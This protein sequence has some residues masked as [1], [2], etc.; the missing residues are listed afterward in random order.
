M[1]KVALLLAFEPRSEIQRTYPPLAL[2]YLASYLRTHVPEVEVRF[3]LTADEAAAFGPDLVGI[4]SV[5]QNLP[6]ATRLAAQLRQATDAPIALGGIHVSLLPETLPAPFDL[7]VL[8]EGER[9]LADL[10]RWRRGELARLDE[11]E[12]LEVRGE[13][14]RLV[15]TPPRTPIANLDE[16]PMPDLEGLGLTWRV[17]YR[18]RVLLYSARGCPYKCLF[19]SGTRFWRNYRVFSTEYLIREIEARS[20]AYGTRYFDFWD[21]LFIGDEKRFRA[22]AEAFMERALAQ[23]VI[24]GFS[25][26]SN[27]VTPERVRAFGAL[28]VENVNFGAESGSDRILAGAHKTGVTVAVNQRAIDLLHDQGIFVNCSFIFGFPDETHREMKQTLQF[29]ERNKEKLAGIG[30]YPLLPFPGTV[31]WD[32]ALAR[33]LVSLDMDWSALEMEYSEMD[34]AKLPY[35]NTQVSRRKFAAVLARAEELRQEIA[36]R[37][38]RRLA[39]IHH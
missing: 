14:G 18:D 9:T 3:C 12:G 2:G 36:A 32:Q 19:C 30:F 8:G 33:H 11:I 26:R 4:S 29:I 39:V 22:F 25:V 31:Y 37:Q 7:G 28:G 24:L 20:T 35:L 16:I 38:E 1:T 6:I 21:D 13:G 5:T 27:L 15:R 17:S 34:P 23:R 10:V